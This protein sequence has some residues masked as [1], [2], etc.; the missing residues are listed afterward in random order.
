[1]TKLLFGTAGRPAST[2][3]DTLAGI[4]QVRKLG[5][6]AM[7][8]EF[9][10]SV[11]IS[12]EKAPLVEKAA[13]ESNVMLTCH[14]QY[15]T[16]LNSSDPAKEKASVERILKAA[17][18]AAAC[19]ASS[20]CFHAAFYSNQ[21]AGLVYNKVR[22][23][24]EQTVS[25]LRGEG[26]RIWIRPE[27]TGK[28]A[29]FGTLDEL[30]RLSSEIEQVMPCIDFS[31]LHARS[32]GE[33][34]SYEEF[35]AVLEKLEKELGKAALKNMHIH[36]SGIAYGPKGEKNHLELKDSDMNYTAVLQVLKDFNAKGVVVCESPNIEDDAL[37]L[38]KAF[39]KL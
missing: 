33:Y 32:N 38:Q 27:T 25:E 4:K 2:Q 15:Y 17:R 21:P 26:N 20:V 23:K 31:H 22:E 35:S 18:T 6:D 10:Y 11:N 9:V 34:N 19:G 24:L 1:M 12:G 28:P 29:Q 5:L 13:K 36:V 3:G 8:L 16:N 14:G 37:L 7:E 30:L 39:E